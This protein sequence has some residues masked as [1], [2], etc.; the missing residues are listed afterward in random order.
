MCAIDHVVLVKNMNRGR[1]G[2]WVSAC[3]CAIDQHIVLVKNMG[4]G[5]GGG[6]GGWYHFVLMIMN[7][8]DLVCLDTKTTSYME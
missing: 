4:G 8:Q 3:V 7:P 5:G 6:G 1:G 2:F